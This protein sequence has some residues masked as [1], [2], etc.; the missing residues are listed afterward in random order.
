M[1]IPDYIIKTV[2]SHYKRIAAHAGC[3][4]GDHLTRDAL[5]QSGRDLRRLEKYIK[6]NEKVRTAPQADKGA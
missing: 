2:Y 6:E 1:Q 4:P 3:D 5:R